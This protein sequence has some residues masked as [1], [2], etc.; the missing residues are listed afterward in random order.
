VGYKNVPFAEIDSLVKALQPNCLV[1]DNNHE[2]NFRHS[3]ILEWE[4]PVVGP[5]STGN[6]M[7]GEGY[8]PISYNMT[9]PE[10]CWFWHPDDEC[11]LMPPQMIVDRLNQCNSNTANYLLSVCPDTTGRLPQCQVDTL[12]SVGSLLGVH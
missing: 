12:N 11:A 6:H 5:P 3:E 2:I 10:R 4:I 1:I 9:K 8:E 7:T